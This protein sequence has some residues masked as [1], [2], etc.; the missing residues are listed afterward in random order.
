MNNNRGN[1]NNNRRRG[2]GNNNG[3]PQGG[4]QQVNRIDS[5]ARGN[6][7]QLLE[8]YRK[9]AHDAHLNGDRVTAEYY[10][11]FA[12]HYFRVI[13]D[14]RQRQEEA[15]ARRDD[16][17]Q[18]GGDS[19]R[20]EG[21]D[22]SDFSVE[23]DFPTFDQP[24]VYTRREREDNG[25]GDGNRVDG[26][27]ADVNRADSSRSD[28][29]RDQRGEHHPR[30]DRRREEAPRREEQP[31]REAEPVETTAS[32]SAGE[33]PMTVYEPAENPFLRESRAARTPRARREDRRPARGERR[34]APASAEAAP[35][36][37]VAPA[38]DPALLPPSISAGRKS[39]EAPVV[40]EEAPAPKKRARR[41]TA[42]E[43]AAEAAGDESL[44]K[45]G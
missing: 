38:M 31:R 35:V 34:E 30:Q 33:E 39:E 6:A 16:R 14:T 43:K 21:D 10:L 5:R 19:M 2:R 24:P 13:A 44:Q 26:N 22:G 36:A 23:S 28:Q 45:V 41:K 15:R 20:D 37:E 9:L 40:A 32:D 17:W 27:R 18:E 11:Q 4:N 12:D 25:R 29:A 3:R 1:N 7:P 42:A 8:K